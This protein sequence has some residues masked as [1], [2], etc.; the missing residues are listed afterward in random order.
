M[1]QVWDEA[2]RRVAVTVLEAGPCP[3]V[4]CKRDETDGY[5][6]AQLGFDAQK[7]Q[8]LTKAESAR[9]TKAGVT[10]C[11]VLREFA[12]DGDEGIEVGQ[13]VSVGIFKDVPLVDVTG[14]SKGRGFAGVIRRHGM[15]GGPKTHGGQSKRRPGSVGHAETPG[16]IQKNKK[17]PGHMGCR[18]V[19]ARN[20]PVIQVRDNE[21]LLLV[22]GAVPGPNGGFVM[23]CKALRKG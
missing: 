15:S 20:L 18:R 10:P 6:A 1:T 7:P 8:R 21:N 22:Q 12:L 16:R 9:F 5:A 13:S 4:Q 19:K 11:R 23:I 2:G 3:V 17:M 14:L